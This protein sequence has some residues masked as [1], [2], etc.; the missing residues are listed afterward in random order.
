MRPRRAPAL[1]ALAAF[2]V[3]CAAVFPAPVV[4]VDMLRRAGDAAAATGAADGVAVIRAQCEHRI[5]ALEASSSAALREHEEKVASLTEE[6]DDLAATVKRYKRGLLNLES[7]RKDEVAK[8]EQALRLAES[9]EC[10]TPTLADYV[11]PA[12]D[13]IRRAWSDARA[14]VA[15][16]RDV[17]ARAVWSRTRS[18]L[19]AGARARR[20]V[21]SRA[22]A[23]ARELFPGDTHDDDAQARETARTAVDVVIG[24]TVAVVI[25]AASSRMSFRPRFKSRVGPT[26]RTRIEVVDED[27]E[28]LRGGAVLEGD[29][30][31]VEWKTYRARVPDAGRVEIE[32]P[33]RVVQRRGA[34]LPDAI[35]AAAEAFDD[36]PEDFDDEK[37]LPGPPASPEDGDASGGAARDDDEEAPDPVDAEE[38]YVDALRERPKSARRVPARVVQTR[39]P[40]PM[41]SLPARASRARAAPAP[42]TP[43]QETAGRS[44]RVPRAVP[45]PGSALTASSADVLD[46]NSASDDLLSQ[47]PWGD[48]GGDGWADTMGTPDFQKKENKLGSP[49]KLPVARGARRVS[50]PLVQTTSPNVVYAPAPPAPPAAKATPPSGKLRLVR[51]GERF[52]DSSRAAERRTPT[53]SPDDGLAGGN[54]RRCSPGGNR[55]SSLG[56]TPDNKQIT[57]RQRAMAYAE[58]R[59]KGVDVDLPSLGGEEGEYVPRG[60]MRH[61][62]AL[63]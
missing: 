45:H 25:V 29:E 60:G 38:K 32:G 22:S 30:G 27:D 51:P 1:L 17:A 21:I 61:R 19:A 63:R 58:A 26:A 48:D 16:A 46:L 39:S 10:P 44:S 8:L 37:E 15:D 49:S 5:S 56:L 50:A 18:A 55:S 35:S 42:R 7:K 43:P 34:R 11:A 31:A 40:A 54:L 53:S 59:R 13:S 33:K 57:P 23:A 28:E 9:G 3:V 41:P 62:G 14:G 36:K 6:R 52:A 20:A 47:H 2:L 12:L 4:A 24:A